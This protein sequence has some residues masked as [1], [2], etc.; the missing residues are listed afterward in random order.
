MLDYLTTAYPVVSYRLAGRGRSLPVTQRFAL[1]RNQPICGFCGVL[2][3][4][5]DKGKLGRT[6]QVMADAIRHRG[7]DSCGS[8]LDEGIALGHRRLS[9]IDL[10][11]A[12]AQPM[13]LG[14]DGPTISYNGEIYNFQALREELLRLGC[15]FF[16]RSDTEVILQAYRMWGLDGLKRLEGIFAF[17]L[18]D[19]PKKRLVLM[20][21]RLGVKPLFYAW[22]GTRLAFGSEIG[23]IVAAGLPDAAID[24]QA[25]AEYLWYGNTFEDRTIYRG[26]RSLPPGH[27]MVVQDGRVRMEPWWRL[28]EW[29]SPN[30]A[31]ATP[32]AAAREL[33]DRLERAV[34]RQ[35]I[36]DV[37]VGIFLSGGLD[38]S[39]IAY[40]AVHD[41]GQTLASYS[42]GFDFE[43]GVNELPKARRIA[44]LLGL[45]H[46]EVPVSVAH[47]R[48]VLMTLARS[49]GEP[50]AD[51]ATIPLYLLSRALK[52]QIKVVLQGDGGDEMFA[53]YR[54]SVMLKHGTA[55]RAWPAWLS[56]ALRA[57]PSH[58]GRRLARMG[59]AMRADDAMRMAL[60]LTVDT[61]AEPPTAFLNRDAR[62][63]LAERADPFLA[64][65]RTADRFASHDPVQQMLLTDLVLQLPSQFLAK[66]DRAT[67]ASG[68][69]ARVPLLDEHVGSLA[70]GLPWAWKVRGREGKAVLRDAMRRKLPDDI[71][72]GPKTGFNVPYQEWLRNGLHEFARAV[73]LDE[74]VCGRF[75]LDRT[76]LERAFAQH[77]AGT[78]EHGFVLWKYF[79]LGLWAG[80]AT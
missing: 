29:L 51:P 79:Q 8:F 24:D 73:V 76:R 16:S 5:E 70:V 10:S 49:F 22:N 9:I 55:W 18:W 31:P 2:D 46:H 50:F 74:R 15:E 32:A 3:P 72:D 52:G 66:V 25:F 20:R 4:A 60:L 57:L 26:I 17:A 21:D 80:V 64:F 6:V 35:L 67:M 34:K 63:R 59:E 69:E 42:A 62:A 39:S 43:G 37:P 1:S 48:D 47:L 13:T 30:G 71:L 77:R 40:S 65:K 12:G 56:A 27:W 23:A 36:A 28:E 68:I 78:R 41:A 7:P 54:R 14:T 53:G 38:S 45:D 33:R 44:D 61:I 19:A 75:G 11:P 58:A